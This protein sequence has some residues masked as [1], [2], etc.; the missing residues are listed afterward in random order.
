[1]SW[2]SPLREQMSLKRDKITPIQAHWNS[3][4]YLWGFWTPY[5]NSSLKVPRDSRWLASQCHSLSCSNASVINLLTSCVLWLCLVLG[6]DPGWSD[7]RLANKSCTPYQ[8]LSGVLRH[9]ETKVVSTSRPLRAELPQPSVA[10]PSQ[11]SLPPL[12][13]PIPVS[14]LHPSQCKG[15][16]L[17]PWSQHNIIR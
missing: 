16:S 9:R 11:S 12:E 10:K 5:R 1:M 17:Q 15:R 7:S 6:A 3:K 4:C 2:H 14:A 8:I 13:S